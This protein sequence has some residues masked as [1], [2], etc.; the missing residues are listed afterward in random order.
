MMNIIIKFK[1][2]KITESFKRFIEEKIGGV[3]KF[4][5][6]FSKN[7]TADQEDSLEAFVE[8]EKETKHH[9]KGDVFKAEAKINL[10][11]KSFMAKA[12]GDDLA[13]TVTEVRD[14]LEDEIRKYKTKVIEAPRRKERK[15]KKFFKFWE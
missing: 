15:L 10:P 9:R 14:E 3:K 8:I 12:H 6:S 4:L 11:G 5:K 2:L 7:T 13:R 1:N